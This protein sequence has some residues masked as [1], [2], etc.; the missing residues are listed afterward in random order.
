MV[1]LRFELNGALLEICDGEARLTGA[2]NEYTLDSFLR[3]TISQL[4]LSARGMLL[5]AATV[6]RDGRA[7]VFMG[8]SGAGKSTIARG[9]PAGSALT[10]EIS[11]VRCHASGWRAHGTPFWGEFRAAGQNASYPLARIFAL[12]QAPHNRVEK[13]ASREALRALLNCS[14]FFS[15]VPED[16][17]ALLSV[18]AELAESGRIYRLEFR[19]ELDF[20]EGVDQWN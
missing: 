8:Q 9:A 18:A 3:V 17:Q 6:V 15:A 14:L 20:W 1:R 12:Q 4:L 16:R 11:L 2:M 19:R 5:H 10:D 13:L 7:Y